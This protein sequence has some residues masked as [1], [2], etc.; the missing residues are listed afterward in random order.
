MRLF[1]LIP[2]A[3]ALCVA[4]A[5]AASLEG[6]KATE[7]EI[8]SL[9]KQVSKLEKRYDKLIKRCT[10]DERNRP[11]ARAC[12][13]ARVTYQDVQQLKKQIAALGV[14]QS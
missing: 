5:S 3:A 1:T 13:T 12:D 14:D 10:G 6:D 9:Q 8:R 7:R 2:I 4:P 11:D